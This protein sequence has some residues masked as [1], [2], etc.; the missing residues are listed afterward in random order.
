M[1]RTVYS[2]GI[3]VTK[4]KNINGWTLFRATMYVGPP[5]NPL[6]TIWFCYSMHFPNT[7]VR[8][9]SGLLF[10]GFN[11]ARLKVLFDFFSFFEYLH[12]QHQ[13]SQQHLVG[14]PLA[15][16]RPTIRSFCLDCP[17]VNLVWA[18]MASSRDPASSPKNGREK[19]S[20]IFKCHMHRVS[21]E[22]YHY[23]RARLNKIKS[24]KMNYTD[25]PPQKITIRLLASI[26]F[27]IGN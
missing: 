24:I 21:K 1:G 22:T 20:K 19:K 9:Y 10:S 6:K 23:F 15:D 13:A 8:V 26:T 11:M 16:E 25:C 2:T 14:W 17:D 27:K 4:G 7:P 5:F 3:C 18:T 12:Y